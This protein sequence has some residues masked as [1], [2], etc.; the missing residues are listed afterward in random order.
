MPFPNPSKILLPIGGSYASRH[1]INWLTEPE[2]DRIKHL[3]EG[4]RLEE[5]HVLSVPSLVNS[6]PKEHL[7]L[8]VDSLAYDPIPIVLEKIDSADISSIE[9]LIEEDPRVE[10]EL[11]HWWSELTDWKEHTEDTQTIEPTQNEVSDAD[12]VFD[13]LIESIAARRDAEHAGP[14][15]EEIAVEAA[16]L[17]NTDEALTMIFEPTAEPAVPGVHIAPEAITDADAERVDFSSIA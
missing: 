2:S 9:K 17:M 12:S 11:L 1:I 15:G 6:I 14:A 13:G 7:P 16:V 10:S 5:A 3:I 4:F 8:S